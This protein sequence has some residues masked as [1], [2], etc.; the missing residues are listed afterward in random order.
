MGN[1]LGEEGL[2]Q[3]GYRWLDN[4]SPC[5]KGEEHLV[6]LLEAKYIRRVG[7]GMKK[8]RRVCRERLRKSGTLRRQKSVTRSKESY[9]NR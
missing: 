7:G 4:Y 6:C 2:R 5:G 8:Y 3:D 1:F 9:S